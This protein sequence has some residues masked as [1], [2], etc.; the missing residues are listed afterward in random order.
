MA[1][2]GLVESALCPQVLTTEEYE[3][4]SDNVRCKIEAFVKNLSE[5]RIVS[6]ALLE[7]TRSNS[8]QAV[9][10]LEL[11]VGEKELECKELNTKLEAENNAFRLQRNAAVDE[12]D[13]LLKIV[14]RRNAELNHLQE[15]YRSLSSQLQTAIAAKWKN[16]W[17]EK[18]SELLEKLKV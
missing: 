4:I 10:A 13:D 14:E 12:R 9:S 6:K 11:K 1:S 2:T 3:S 16:E 8:E 5:D 15:D 18:E 17:K 7:T